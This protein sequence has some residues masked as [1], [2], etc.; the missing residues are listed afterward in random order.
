MNLLKTLVICLSVLSTTSVSDK[1]LLQQSHGLIQQGKSLL[2]QQEEK[3]CIAEALWYEARG[4]GLQGMKYVLSVIHNRKESKTYPSTYC[5]VIKQYKQFSYRNNFQKEKVM[6][7][8]RKPVG[9]SEEE[10][11]GWVLS[12]AENASK[13]LFKPLLKPSV[14]HYH[15][16]DVSP[17]WKVAY[18]V[19]VQHGKH[20][21]LAKK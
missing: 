8:A 14:M 7:I 19:E 9:A 21:F 5:K 17:Y 6:D 20:V 4:E 18:K 11:K 3:K 15:T 13:G 12:L 1:N 10:V 2:K 16:T